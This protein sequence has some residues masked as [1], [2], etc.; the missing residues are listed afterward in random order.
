MIKLFQLDRLWNEIRDDALANIDSV[1]SL[2]FGQKGPFVEKVESWLCEYS[3]RK[4][5]ITLGSGTDALTCILQSLNLPRHSCVA[6][7]S[8]S[9]IA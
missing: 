6:V 9:F 1:A 4:H 8:Y 2:G 3:G 7:P 5:A